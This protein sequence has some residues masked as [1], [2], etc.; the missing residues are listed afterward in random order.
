MTSTAMPARTIQP[1]AR[2]NGM[3][4]PPT[5]YLRTGVSAPAATRPAS[6][7]KKA[8]RKYPQKFASE[9]GPLLKLDALARI[10]PNARQSTPPEPR[11]S[12]GDAPPPRTMLSI[13]QPQR[14]LEVLIRGRHVDQLYQPIRQDAN[15][16]MIVARPGYLAAAQQPC[17]KTSYS[18]TMA[19]CDLRRMGR[20]YRRLSLRRCHPCR[21]PPHHQRQP[22]WPCH[23]G[24]S[25]SSVHPTK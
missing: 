16:H 25:G 22:R 15:S 14:P 23:Y 3:V 20:R 2:R 8:T 18:R 24:R 9:S 1:K 19:V 4:F 5:R 13:V 17:R 21:N 6:A 7:T 10:V 11:A 12:T